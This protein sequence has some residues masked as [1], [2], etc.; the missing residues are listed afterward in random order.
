MRLLIAIL[1]ISFHVFASSLDGA[2]RAYAQTDYDRA[3]ELVRKPATWEE[4]LVAGKSWYMKQEFKRATEFLEKAAALAPANSP[5]ASEAE[6]WLGRAY[7]RRAETSS[8]IAAPGFASKAR[9]HFERAVE[10]DG[11]NKEALDDLF[12]YYLSAPGF[13]GGGD[14]KAEAL[15][16]KIAALDPAE[17]YF[18]EAKLAEKHKQFEKA[19]AS[20]RRAVELAPRQA[21]RLIDLAKLLYRTGRVKEGEAAFQRAAQLEPR[22]SSVLFE[23]AATYVE[24]KR[25]FREAAQ[26]LEQYLKS[27]LTPDQPSRSDAEKLLRAARSATE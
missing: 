19:E 11:T 24:H 20:L 8:F 3:L 23:R 27:D 9:Q 4:F 18:A 14:K 21:G 17:R 7:G 5:A 6:L 26:L 1:L 15:V 13:L 25:N 10:L 22:N 2:K 16:A 12:E